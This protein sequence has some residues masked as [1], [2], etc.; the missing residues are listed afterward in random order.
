MGAWT[1]RRH[2]GRSRT[3]ATSSTACSS[4]P[5]PMPSRRATVRAPCACRRGTEPGSRRLELLPSTQHDDVV[6]PRALL[7]IWADGLPLDGFD[8]DPLV[9][10][11]GEIQ[12]GDYLF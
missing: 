1:V 2:C 4:P 3:A 9:V 12:T 6:H 10:L 11:V 8:T 7:S 5:R